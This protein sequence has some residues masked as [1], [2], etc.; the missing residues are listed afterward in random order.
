[1]NKKKLFYN[2]LLFILGG[3]SFIGIGLLVI[4][5][6]FKENQNEVE[7]QAKKDLEG[8]TNDLLAKPT[9][10]FFDSVMNKDL[11]YT[12]VDV[13][14]KQEIRLSDKKGKLLVVNLWST[15]CMPCIAELPYFSKLL[16]ETKNE[17]IEYFF[18]SNED[19]EKLNDFKIDKKLLLPIY[20]SNLIDV[21]SSSMFFT[22][23]IPMTIIISPNQDFYLRSNGSASWYSKELKEFLIKMSK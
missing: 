6:K 17:N 14:T 7:M 3:F 18:L 2:F 12:F 1:M 13:A 15:W 23:S 9:L 8:S 22:S 5:Y 11:D 20:K 4:K 19:T 10:S 16:N 21:D